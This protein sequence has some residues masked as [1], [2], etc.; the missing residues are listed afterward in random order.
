MKLILDPEQSVVKW[1]EKA[2]L[3][4]WLCIAKRIKSVVLMCLM[5][6][7]YSVYQQL[8][9]KIK[10]DFGCIKEALYTPFAADSFAAYE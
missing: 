2:E 8:S 5:G 10:N 9:E 1:M 6:G 4:C 3:I 7:A